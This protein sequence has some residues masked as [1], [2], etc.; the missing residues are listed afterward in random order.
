VRDVVLHPPSTPDVANPNSYVCHML[1]ASFGIK[2]IDST[3]RI[4]M[5]TKANDRHK[6]FYAFVRGGFLVHEM[7]GT[8]TALELAKRDVLGVH[9]PLWRMLAPA[10]LI[11]GMASFRKVGCVLFG[12]LV[13]F[14]FWW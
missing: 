1:A 14:V 4:L 10:V 5:Y 9:I 6:G 7:C 11:H 8:M 3:R 2:L 12:R 13:L